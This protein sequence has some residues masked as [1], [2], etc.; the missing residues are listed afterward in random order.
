MDT[1]GVMDK[2]REKTR[3]MFSRSK[4]VE[5]EFIDRCS[6]RMRSDVYEAWDHIVGDVPR[7]TVLTRSVPI[8]SDMFL[9]RDFDIVLHTI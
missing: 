2:M 1:M 5:E 4:L 3:S 7:V 6:I 9:E 8:Q